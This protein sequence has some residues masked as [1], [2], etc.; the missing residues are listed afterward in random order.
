MV[1]SF[2]NCESISK[3]VVAAHGATEYGVNSMQR[4]F[5]TARTRPVDDPLIIPCR[6]KEIRL[7]TYVPVT[8]VSSVVY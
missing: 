3:T 4:R 5:G 8:D 2:L 6:D 7:E 1:A